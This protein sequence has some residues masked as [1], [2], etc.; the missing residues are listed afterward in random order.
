MIEQ[1]KIDIFIEECYE[2]WCDKNIDEL[3]YNYEHD[4][5]ENDYS[6]HMVS[7]CTDWREERKRDH[8]CDEHFWKRSF[9]MT[10]EDMYNILKKIYKM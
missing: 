3:R 6:P 8:F 10:Y 7:E 9:D 5:I 2:D 4:L 1:E